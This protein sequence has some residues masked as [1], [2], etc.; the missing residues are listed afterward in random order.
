MSARGGAG[1]QAPPRVVQRIG[2]GLALLL[3][4]GPERWADRDALAT[5]ALREATGI[6]A[7]HIERR[8]S[9][10]PR[11]APPLSELAVSMAT[12]Q[13]LL[14]AGFAPAGVV[15]VDLETEAALGDGDPLRL[16]RDHFSAAE[17]RA[18]ARCRTDGAARELFLRLWTAKEA[19]LKSTGRGVYDGLAAPDFADLS[20][21]CLDSLGQDGVAVR[22]AWPAAAVTHLAGT[23]LSTDAGVV[24][25]AL[26]ITEAA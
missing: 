15:G 23:R 11:L 16:A 20:A 6:D 8:A 10:R 12:R 24:Y 2:R 7:I 9:G 1:G 5:A 21:G 22:L 25:C 18:V 19:V 3:W 26:A 14:L 4:I 13:P 17:A